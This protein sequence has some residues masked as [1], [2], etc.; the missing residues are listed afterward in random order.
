MKKRVPIYWLSL[1]LFFVAVVVENLT[2]FFETGSVVTITRIFFFWNIALTVLSTCFYLWT[3]WKSGYYFGT[4]ALF[5]FQSFL[6]WW[7]TGVIASC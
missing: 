5:V 6:I 3:F 7:I 1:A 4:L 2:T